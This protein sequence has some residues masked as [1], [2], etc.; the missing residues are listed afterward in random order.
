[1]QKVIKY[2]TYPYAMIEVCVLSTRF[3]NFYLRKMWALGLKAYN[4]K[5]GL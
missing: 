4:K 5:N 1:M 3:N 2:Q